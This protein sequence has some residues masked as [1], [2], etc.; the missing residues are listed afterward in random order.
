MR[1]VRLQNF[2]AGIFIVTLC[3]SCTKSLAN[4]FEACQSQNLL[5][6]V[7]GIRASGRR[8]DWMIGNS[9]MPLSYPRR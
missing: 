8:S 5:S 1:F 9:Q 7:D 6:G 2:M 4:A 3:C